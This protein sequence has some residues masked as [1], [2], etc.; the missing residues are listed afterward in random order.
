MDVI[1]VAAA[2]YGS[3]LAQLRI[4]HT[5]IHVQVTPEGPVPISMVVDADRHRHRKSAI[6]K[7]SAKPKLDA[8]GHAVSDLIMDL[9][10]KAAERCG[11]SEG[12][13]AAVAIDDRGAL[14][15]DRTSDGRRLRGDD[16]EGSP[17]PFGRLLS[18]PPESNVPNYAMM[19]EAYTAIG[20]RWLVIDIATQDVSF[21]FDPSVPVTEEDARG[22]V[23]SYADVLQQFAE[24]VVLRAKIACSMGIVGH[25]YQTCQV[26]YAIGSGMA[27]LGPRDDPS[28]FVKVGAMSTALD[29]SRLK[30][31]AAI[32]ARAAYD[33]ITERDEERL[34]RVAEAFARE[35]GGDA[36][37]LARYAIGAAQ[38]NEGAI[39]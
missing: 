11:L 23:N 10:C 35:N 15:V 6:A 28:A 29:P 8:V 19:A 16:G 7:I 18:A 4:P 33:A 2:H 38:R 39:N 31:S 20:I 17:R 14:Y 25:D 12:E 13:I 1:D 30:P 5:V 34:G 21:N 22:V 27:F 24:E 37:D 26:R 3:V 9:S 36:S 32:W